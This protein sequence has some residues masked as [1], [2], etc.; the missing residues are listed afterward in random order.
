MGLRVE[1]DE[2]SS[3]FTVSGRGELHLAILIE[4]MRREGY[5]M[6]ISRPQVIYKEVD[7]VMSEP[8]EEV[9]IDVD[10]QYTG[11]VSEEFGKRRGQL[12]HLFT[13]KDSTNRLV[14]KISSQ[15][16]IGI[17]STLMTQTRGTAVMSSILLGYE[18]KG[19]PLPTIRNG[20][21]IAYEAGTALTYGLINAQER[22]TLFI[23]PGTAVYQGM[24]VGLSS[25]EDDIEVNVCKEKKLTNNRSKGE[26]VK[27]ALEPATIMSLEQCLDFI[28][29][30]ELLEVTPV[31]LRLR[32]RY[33]SDIERRRHERSGR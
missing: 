9:T 6:D 29:D 4:T 21:I 5:E 2:A 15:N 33:L 17:R 30:D 19:Q 11:V 12:L 25:R 32:K 20:A 26:G 14:F 24:V 27:E 8:F 18:P 22:G 1:E 28:A 7:G 31:A 23:N 16:L 10:S 13:L 3:N